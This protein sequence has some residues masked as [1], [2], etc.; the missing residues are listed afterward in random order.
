MSG[1]A[2]KG[3]QFFRTLAASVLAASLVSGGVSFYFRDTK[4]ERT[5]EE[6]AY[7]RVVRAGVL[8]CGYGVSPPRLVK[9]PNTGKLSGVDFDIW[10]RI[11]QELGVKIDWVEDSGWGS[12]IQDLKN[13]RFDAFCSEMFPDPARIK[14]LSLTDPVMYTAQYAHVRAD[15]FRFDG[16]ADL[17]NSE[18]ATLAVIEGDVSA[19][20]EARKF[21]RARVLSLPQTATVSDMFLS[22]ATGKASV[23]FLDRAMFLALDRAHPGKLRRVANIPP[24]LF[25]ATYFGFN[26]GEV[27]LRDAVNAALRS[28]VDD[29]SM[30]AFAKKVDEEVLAPRPGYGS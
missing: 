5:A 2:R 29:G 14:F 16:R 13:G 7:A 1:V 20:V 4:P 9:D 10:E 26:A 25:F 8:R 22:V 27:Q 12:F 19:L 24:G 11:G 18:A 17:L 15:D 21:P 28:I 3:G 6:S 23:V 30:D